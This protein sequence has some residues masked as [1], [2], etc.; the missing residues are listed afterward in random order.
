MKKDEYRVYRVE[1]KKEID[2]IKKK[3]LM[4]LLLMIY[5]EFD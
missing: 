2:R 3:S 4:N 5:K 1:F